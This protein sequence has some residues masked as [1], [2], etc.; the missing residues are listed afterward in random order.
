RVRS[1]TGA[2]IDMAKP[3]SRIHG[4]ASLAVLA[5]LDRADA[6]VA[7]SGLQVDLSKSDVRLGIQGS[8]GGGYDISKHLRV[9][10]SV[11]VSP[12]FTVKKTVKPEGSFN[13]GP[14]TSSPPPMLAPTPIVKFDV[15]PKAVL[16]Y[17][18]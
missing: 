6:R 17:N 16:S 5:Q 14:V 4:V 3:G 15:T 9:L 7:L 18:W 12:I 8:V 1:A 11:D 13:G 2:Q 10:G